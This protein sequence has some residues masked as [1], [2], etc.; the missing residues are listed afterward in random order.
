MSIK[1]IDQRLPSR[2]VPRSPKHTFYLETEPFQIQPFLL[3]PVLP[4]ETMKKLSLQSKVVTDPLTSNLMGWWKEYYIFYVKHRDLAG[5]SDF[6]SMMLD[7][8]FDMSGQQVVADIQ[9]HH[10]DTTINWAAQCTDAVVAEYFRGEAEGLG[11]TFAGLSMAKLNSKTFTDTIISESLYETADFDVDLDADATVTVSEVER[12]LKTWEMLRHNNMT[13]M[14]YEDY[15]RT[16]GVKTAR[17][18]YNKP[19]LIRYIR[20]WTYPTNTIDP[21]DG[22]PTSACV[23]NIS[24][25]ADK[26]RYFKEPGFIFGVTVTRPKIRDRDL[27]GSASDWL[28]NAVSW[29][30][31]LLADDPSTSMRH[32]AI[33]TGP[34][35]EL[36][37]AAYYIDQRD[38][39]IH[40]DD[41]YNTVFSDFAGNKSNLVT[42]G[43]YIDQA[44][45]PNLFTTTDVDFIKEDGVVDLVIM[46]KQVDTTP[47]GRNP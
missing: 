12:A 22:S 9:T 26:D 10:F 44:F 33:N 7:A 14:S 39:F 3:A 45:I 5:S 13:D 35:Q 20:D 18:E 38:L 30:P 6:Q 37:D 47:F 34:A 16:H 21:A 17:E 41:F 25:T 2:R 28:D 24:E 15:L 43:E 23:W 31:A 27:K 11:P 19:E 46:G 36:E 42:G 4:G 32:Y 1:V 29:L 8:D 40:G